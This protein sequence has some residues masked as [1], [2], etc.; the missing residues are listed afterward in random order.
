[1]RIRSTYGADGDAP[2]RLDTVFFCNS[3]SEAND[4]AWRMACAFT[5]TRLKASYTS[6]LRPHALVLMTS[7]GGWPVPLLVLGLRPHTLV[8]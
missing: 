3:G 1:M 4:L 7:P 6:S 5:G 2:S 8:A